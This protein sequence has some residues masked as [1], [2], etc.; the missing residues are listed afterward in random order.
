MVLYGTCNSV[1]YLLS[2]FFK[3]LFMLICVAQV[4][5][6]LLEYGILLYKYS[7][8]YFCILLF[9]DSLLPVFAPL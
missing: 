1:A 6:F 9:I 4:Y 5:S 8:M 2:A 3:D 7:A